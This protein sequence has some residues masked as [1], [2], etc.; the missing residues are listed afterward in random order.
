MPVKLRAAVKLVR[1]VCGLCFCLSALACERKPEERKLRQGPVGTLIGEVTLAPGSDLPAYTALDLVRRTLRYHRL[2]EP[3]NECIEANRNARRPVT[4]TPEGRLRGIVV[5]A[6][7]FTRVR[8]R[9]PKEHRLRIEHCQ[10]QPSI[11]AAQG[12]DVLVLENHDAYEF[13]PL[14]GPAYE[15]R[16][17]PRGKPWKIPL[18]ASGIDTVQCSLH[19][20]C[21]RA[22]LLVFHHPVNTVSD[23]DG[24][25]RIENFPAAELVRVTAWHPL[26]EPKETFVWL[27][28]GQEST[29]KLQLTPKARFASAQ[30]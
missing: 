30:P 24:K 23:D 20:P 22:E 15:S 27:D 29:I 16:G 4:L 28:P 9:K 12:G 14:V 19:A 2:P 8:E 17:L 18:I 26:F 25:F 6:S 3:P 5:A 1:L 21:G 10:L 11:I 7:D 13:E